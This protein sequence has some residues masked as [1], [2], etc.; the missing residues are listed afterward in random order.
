MPDAIAFEATEFH[1]G[2]LKKYIKRELKV[3]KQLFA[4]NF[5]FHYG[6]FSKTPLHRASCKMMI[7]IPNASSRHGGRKIKFTARSTFTSL[8]SGKRIYRPEE[9]REYLHNKPRPQ[10]SACK[11]ATR[12]SAKSRLNR[13]VYKKSIKLEKKSIMYIERRKILAENAA[14]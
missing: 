6:G 1:H 11:A 5:H 10:S 9:S 7:A 3:G 8:F 13:V 14:E 12:R 4:L 2:I